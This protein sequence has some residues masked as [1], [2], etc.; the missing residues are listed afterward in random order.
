VF[1]APILAVWIDR[2]SPTAFWV[3]LP[4]RIT[5][6][7][8][9]W[10]CETG[11]W[12]LQLQGRILSSYVRLKVKVRQSLHR[13]GQALRVHNFKTFGIWRCKLVN[14]MH[15]P[16]TSQDI[17]LVLISVRGWVDIRAILR[18]EG[19]G[20]WKILVTLSGIEPVTFQPVA[21]CLSQLPQ[22]EPQLCMYLPKIKY[23]WSE[24]V[25][26]GKC[27]HRLS[28]KIRVS[29]SFPIPSH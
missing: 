1:L 26:P 10:T 22:R 28:P 16:F 11:K 7:S 18:P 20:Q 15:R 4:A 21:L 8:D 9:V 27:R 12:R 19:L 25:L 17:F 5:N 14:P 24:S 13:T 3:E 23:L 6:F 29:A 2:C